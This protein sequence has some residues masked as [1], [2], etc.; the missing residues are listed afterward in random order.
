[1]NFAAK[2]EAVPSADWETHGWA[3]V[4]DFLSAKE[5]ADL[6]A[7]AGRLCAD[8]FNPAAEARRP[9]QGLSR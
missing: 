3:L 8:R 6:R 5:I 7:E 9:R 4:P 1:M 2:L